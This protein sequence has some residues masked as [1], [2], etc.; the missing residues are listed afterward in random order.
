MIEFSDALGDGIEH[1]KAGDEFP[2]GVQFDL[3]P[4]AAERRDSLGQQLGG[5]A[6]A[7]QV[8]WSG[9]DHFPLPDSPGYR[10]RGDPRSRKACRRTRNPEEF[11]P[12]HVRLHSTT[13]SLLKT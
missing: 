9:R 8:P 13:V 11:P 12:F 1:T 6:R 10:R 7:R 2:C 3:Q 5:H 4:A